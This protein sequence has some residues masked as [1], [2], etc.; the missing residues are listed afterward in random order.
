[1]VQDI[2]LIV[3]SAFGV[4]SQ[5]GVE[6]FLAIYNGKYNNLE[7]YIINYKIEQNRIPVELIPIADD[8][9]GNLICISSES[10]G[11]YFWDHEK[12]MAYYRKE[13]EFDNV[14]YLISESLPKFFDALK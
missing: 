4:I 10:G 1:M 11:I 8:P 13:W 12:E 9:L 2:K 7:R 6:L 14:Y 3:L 5:S